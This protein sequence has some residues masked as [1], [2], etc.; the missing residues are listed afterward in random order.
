MKLYLN[1]EGDHSVGIGNLYITIDINCNI[2]EEEREIIKE[3]AKKFMSEYLDPI[4]RIDAHFEDECAD[5][6]K[7]LI[8]KECKNKN[9]IRNW[10]EESNGGS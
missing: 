6:E 7:K 3:G 2:L 9:C 5:C 4:G 8:N 10:K 1:D